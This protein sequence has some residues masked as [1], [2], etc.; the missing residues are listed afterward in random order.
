[1][2]KG[3]MLIAILSFFSAIVY[4]LTKK[5]NSKKIPS[6]ILVVVGFVFGFFVPFSA[7]NVELLDKLINNLLPPMMFLFSLDLDIERIFKN[8]I[9]CSCKMGAKRYALLLAI[10][11]FVSLVS[12]LIALEF[13]SQYTLTISVLIAFVS[14]YIASFTRLKFLNGSEDLAT[15]MLY[16][17]SGVVGLRIFLVVYNL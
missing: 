13:H 10:A 3:I 16:L 7:S 17:L 2:I 6:F 1:M 4:F 11:F 8:E 14:G 12:Q 5:L 9:G 15:S